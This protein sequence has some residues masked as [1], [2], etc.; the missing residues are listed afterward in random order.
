M[1]IYDLLALEDLFSICHNTARS[2]RLSL[3]KPLNV[4]EEW[5]IGFIGDKLNNGDKIS[6]NDFLVE[7]SKKLLETTSKIEDLYDNLIEFELGHIKT[8]VI[9][10]NGLLVNMIH[11][12]GVHT[13]DDVHV[14]VAYT[15]QVS[16]N[17]KVV[18]VTQDYGVISKK[19][20][21]FRQNVAIELSDPLYAVYHF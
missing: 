4:V 6:V 20:N 16:N 18:F 21:L 19:T 10:V 5:A 3:I 2:R 1:S 12:E 14:A 11:D 8:K 13:P 17:E 7:L 15:Y 9:P